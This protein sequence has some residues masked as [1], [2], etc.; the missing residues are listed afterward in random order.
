MVKP[1]EVVPRFTTTSDRAKCSSFH[2]TRPWILISL[3]DGSIQLWDYRIGARLDVF[4][5][6]TSAVRAVS[7]HPSNPYFVSGDDDGVLKIWDYRSRHW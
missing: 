5:H 4:T 2:P 6:G 1:S 3:R 7:F